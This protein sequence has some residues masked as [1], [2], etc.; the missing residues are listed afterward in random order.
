MKSNNGK[1]YTEEMKESILKRMMPP[2]NESVSQ[3]SKELGITE[4]TLYG[5]N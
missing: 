3:I 1:R 4:P 2:N 5:A